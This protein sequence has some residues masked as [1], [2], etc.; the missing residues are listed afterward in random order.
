[1][2]IYFG[3]LI[4]QTKTILQVPNI[5][6]SMLNAQKFWSKL[7]IHAKSIAV[8]TECEFSRDLSIICEWM[9]LRWDS[10]APKLVQY[11]KDHER[12]WESFFFEIVWESQ[13]W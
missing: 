13:Y 5:D 9:F 2:E 12:C 7:L 3:F 1:M 6:Y 8:S 10:D 11:Q 4:V